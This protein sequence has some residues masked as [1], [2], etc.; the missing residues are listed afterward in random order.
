ME[1]ADGPVQECLQLDPQ[2][3]EAPLRRVG[4]TAVQTLMAIDCAVFMTFGT[5]GQSVR[6]AWRPGYSP[7]GYWRIP[8]WRKA[9]WTDS[10]EFVTMLL[11]GLQVYL[12]GGHLLD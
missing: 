2:A 4:A 3:L 7:F 10:T 9:P 6:A 12:H 8:H 11:G 1:R 5:H